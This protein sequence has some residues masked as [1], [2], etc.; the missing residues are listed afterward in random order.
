MIV[1]VGGIK[2][3]SGKTTMAVNLTVRHAAAGHSVLLIDADDQ[4]TASDFA[5]MRQ[6]KH[7]LNFECVRKSGISLRRFVES[8][9][10]AYDSI[11]ID[12]GGR[13]TASQRA[14]MSVSDVMAVPF[15]PRSF[16]IWTLQRLR[17]LIGEV[18]G[19]GISIET[20]VFLNR[21]D[22]RGPDN[23]E[24][25]EAIGACEYLNFWPGHI[26]ARKA[27]ANS[28]AHGLGIGEI[29][30]GDKKAVEEFQDFYRRIF[31]KKDRTNGH[32]RFA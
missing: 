13:D 23:K 30:P 12:A 2:G 4:G 24:A 16:D 3:G 9:H 27:F 32:H 5:T 28:A 7:V 15:V 10:R 31:N 29:R 14:A 22:P 19:A 11:V 1:T 6:W 17:Q 8:T 25:A 18:R 21:A 26:G 20:C